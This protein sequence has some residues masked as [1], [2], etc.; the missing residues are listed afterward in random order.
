M[1]VLRRLQSP[2]HLEGSDRAA[3][4]LRVENNRVRKLKVYS[5][6]ERAFKYIEG[7]LTK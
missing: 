6:D 7:V 5:L 4:L 1:G 3:V 2:I